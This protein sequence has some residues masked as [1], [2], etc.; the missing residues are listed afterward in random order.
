MEYARKPVKEMTLG[1]TAQIGVAEGAGIAGGFIGAG[2]LGRQIENLVKKDVTQ[3]SSFTDKGL[4]WVANNLPKVAVW[5]LLKQY[6]PEPKPGDMM[7]EVVTDVKKSMMGSMFYDSTLRLANHGV[8]PAEV[9]IGGFRVMNNLGTI[10]HNKL[11]LRDTQIRQEARQE[12]QR[13]VQA[14]L[15]ASQHSSQNDAQKLVQ[16]NSYLRQQLHEALTR[17]TNPAKSVTNS[18]S[19]QASQTTPEAENRRREFGSMPED[20]TSPEAEDRRR[21][22]G[23]MPTPPPMEKRQ[24]NYGFMA[25]NI[26]EKDVASVFGML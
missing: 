1:E 6:G 7:S 8:N 9:R 14:Q 17:L 4:A 16:E 11:A 24:T 19:V 23:S 10:D 20:G 15:Q 22:F 13:Q 3:S 5:Y 26:K 18:V 2:V 12:A 25:S 21:E